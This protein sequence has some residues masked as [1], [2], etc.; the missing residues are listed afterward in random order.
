MHAC[1]QFPS[2]HGVHVN[3]EKNHNIISLLDSIIHFC[4][5][6]AS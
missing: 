3:R 4:D 1:N 6:F 2:G 5:R